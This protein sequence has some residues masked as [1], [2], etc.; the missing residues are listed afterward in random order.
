MPDATPARRPPAGT[1]RHAAPEDTD[2]GGREV[3]RWTVTRVWHD[4]E[5]ATADEAIGRASHGGHDEVRAARQ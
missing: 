4:V 2:A 5:A 1:P 3:P